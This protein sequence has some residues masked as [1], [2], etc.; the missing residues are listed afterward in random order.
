MKYLLP[1]LLLACSSSE[2]K[3]AEDALV[4]ATY[5]RSLDHC[6]EL[7][8]RSG[9]FDVYAACAKAVDRQLCASKGL[10]C[11]EVE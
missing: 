2:Q 1:V 10:M 11:T 7:G 5:E 9:S 3:R 6:R 4:I 8:K